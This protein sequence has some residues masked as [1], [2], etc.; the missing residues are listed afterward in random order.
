MKGLFELKEPP[1]A[2]ICCTDHIAYQCL[3]ALDRLGIEVPQRVSV[4]GYDGVRW[5]LDVRHR[6]ASVV[7]DFDHQAEAAVGLLIDGYEP[8]QSLTTP[9][10]FDP[11]TTLGPACNGAI[12]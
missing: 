3:L 4:I 8:G 9:T 11:G 7:V 10:T 2:I 6:V 1:T 5:P 12:K